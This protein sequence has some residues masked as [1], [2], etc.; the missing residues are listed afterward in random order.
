MSDAHDILTFWFGEPAAGAADL[1]RKFQRWYVA[2]ASFDREIAERFA[3]D[4]ERALAGELDG[5]SADPRT[6]LA[7]ILLLDQFSR[8][9]FRGQPRAFAGDAAAQRLALELFERGLERG[10]ALEERLFLIMPLLHAEDLAVQKRVGQL[11]EQLVADAPAELRPIYAM[12]AEQSDKYSDIIARFGRFPHRNA[13]LGR[14]STPAELE[15]LRDWTTRQQ[16]AG[17]H[18]K[19]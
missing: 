12:S 15:F 4:V 11:C 7:L 14:V 3:G 9:I 13:A 19:K 10:F 2:D 8:T 16:P 1:Q 6:R 18:D 5:W 17:M